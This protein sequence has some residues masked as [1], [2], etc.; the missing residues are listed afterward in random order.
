MTILAEPE[1]TNEYD[2]NQTV[3]LWATFKVSGVLTDPTQVTLFVENPSRVES[4]YYYT[5]GTIQR[6]STGTY[7]YDLSLNDNGMWYYK[8][9]GDGVD[10]VEERS[11]LVRRSVFA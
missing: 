7:Y 2:L 9:D 1:P 3:R 8:F 4:I 5:S 6:L 10:A 11:I